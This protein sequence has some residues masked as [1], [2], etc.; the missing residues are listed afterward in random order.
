MAF[1]QHH[2]LIG[3][4]LVGNK[5]SLSGNQ[6]KDV[7]KVQQ[8]MLDTMKTHRKL[9]RKELNDWQFARQARY[10]TEMPR[11]HFLQEVY[12]DVMMDG[13]LTGITENRTLRTTN[14]DFIICDTLKW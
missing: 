14:K 7:K 6:S 3:G 1:T 9:W 11:N 12:E 4:N 5:I 2:T 8:L 10:S 13:H